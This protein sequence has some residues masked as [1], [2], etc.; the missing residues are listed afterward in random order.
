MGCPP[1]FR[2]LGLTRFF[3]V[4]VGFSDMGFGSTFGQL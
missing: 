1:W 3:G 4:D 2:A